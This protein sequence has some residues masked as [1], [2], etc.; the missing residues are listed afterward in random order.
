[1][2]EHH[3]DYQDNA[4]N[5]WTA[6]ARFVEAL[7]QLAA[8]TK[9]RDEWQTK[10]ISEMVRYENTL[11]AR[12]A[13]IAE[14]QLF[15]EEQD[16]DRE[17]GWQKQ[18]T[19]TRSERDAALAK[20]VRLTARL[21]ETL[22]D[23]DTWNCSALLYHSELR[24]LASGKKVETQ[25][26][27]EVEKVI[28]TLK[29][30]LAARDATIAEI[31]EYLWPNQDG[32]P[33]VHRSAI[34]AIKMREKLMKAQISDRDATIAELQ[35]EVDKSHSYE[36]L[37]NEIKMESARERDAAL[38]ELASV[39]AERRHFEDHAMTLESDLAAEREKVKTLRE[40]LLEAMND[41][42]RW[43]EGAFR[44]QDR[45]LLSC[46]TPSPN[47]IHTHHKLKNALAATKPK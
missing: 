21:A 16:E 17:I 32:L 30:Q 20:N 7:D 45:T 6:T 8:I 22:V 10:A 2:S 24:D 44:W 4:G 25:L 26:G 14:L 11:A 35:G 29:Q 15:L 19:Q 43:D 34:T 9:E 23:R 33:S 47:W 28:T 38:A 12:D 37:A 36:A 13:T 1:M 39:K 40:A 31:G 42:C 3:I 46:V 41:I 18:M 27:F 5:Q